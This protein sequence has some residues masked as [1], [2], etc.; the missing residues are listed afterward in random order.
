MKDEIFEVGKDYRTN[1]LSFQ[2]GGSYVE[3]KFSSGQNFGYDNVHFPKHY[4]R[5][6]CKRHIEYGKVVKVKV[7]GQVVNF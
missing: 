5:A 2:E 1:P 3:V 7:N 6:I 4:V